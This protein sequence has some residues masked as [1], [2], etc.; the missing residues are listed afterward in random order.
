MKILKRNRVAFGVI[1]FIVLLA[2]QI[3]LGKTGHLIASV[4]P[5]QKIDPYDS[6]AE[7]SIHHAF[8]LIIALLIILFLS[9]LLNLDFFFR[10]GDKKT[11]IKSVILFGLAFTAISIAQHTLMV[12]NNQL[13][14]Y[15]F[16]LDGKNILGTLGFQLLLS[17]PAEEV[18]FR[19]LPII[20]LTYS[21]G[22]SIKI[23]GNLTLE[24]ILA[25]VLFA[26]AHINWSLM[27]LTFEVNFFQV[28]YAFVLGTIQG[29][30]YQRCKSILYPVLMH[31]I[32][33]VLMVSG[34][35]VFTA[36]FS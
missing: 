30:V 7:I 16:P 3:F 34:G 15:A 20:L 28:I 5:Y 13:P 27:P 18:L 31:S 6:F 8:E 4:I 19:A 17:G 1:V 22:K 21:F 29:I 12:V 25:S 32:S 9:K 14:S 26:F 11:G 23:K 10:L 2:V 24:V 35:Y 36:L 33:N